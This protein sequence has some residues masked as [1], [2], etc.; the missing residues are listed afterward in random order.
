MDVKSAFPFFVGAYAGKERL[1]HDD[2]KNGAIFDGYPRTVAQAESLDA[3]LAKL[4]RRIDRVVSLEVP[5]D[6]I[7]EVIRERAP[8]RVVTGAKSLSRWRRFRSGC[9][10][11]VLARRLGLEEVFSSGRGRPARSFPS[12]LPLFRLD[13]IYVRG[14]DVELAESHFGLPWSR[15]S[16]H[17]A[18]TANLRRRHGPAPA[19]AR[20]TESALQS[21]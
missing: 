8:D 10:P 5:L 17:A 14:F 21:C 20:S 4:D 16:D 13:R 2:A 19:P 12:S 3:L 18:L 15:I 11:S 6:A 7:V 9:L 1:T